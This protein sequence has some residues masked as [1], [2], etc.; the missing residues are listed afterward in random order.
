MSYFMSSMPLAGLMEMPPASKVSPLPT[1]ASLGASGPTP[2]CRSTIR[3]GGWS[4][5]RATDSKASM[6]SAAI[7]SR[8]RIVHVSPT[9][10][11][12]SRAS[13]AKSDG[14]A[15]LPGRACSVRAKFW[16]SAYALPIATPRLHTSTS[17]AKIVADATAGTRRPPTRTGSGFSSPKRHAASASPSASSWPGRPSPSPS[18]WDAHTASEETPN[19]SAARTALP[20]SSR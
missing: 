17:L 15:K 3:R 10:A 14:V 11:A 20:P 9:A 8:P 6:P 16:A 18:R 4:E 12:I 13:S 1:I 19:A 7:S 2:S 5:P